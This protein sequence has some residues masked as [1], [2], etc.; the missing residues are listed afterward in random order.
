[1]VYGRRIIWESAHHFALHPEPKSV[2]PKILV[3]SFILHSL[4]LLDNFFVI[5]N[6]VWY[7][8]HVSINCFLHTLI[9]FYYL[10]SYPNTQTL[11]V[12]VHFMFG[13]TN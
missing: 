8:L 12:L 5:P 1:M 3:R 7:Q 2:Q 9:W 11:F 10:H 13:H 6:I 4:F